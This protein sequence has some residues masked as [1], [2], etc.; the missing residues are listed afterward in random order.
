MLKLSPIIISVALLIGCFGEGRFPVV[1]NSTGEKFALYPNHSMVME[2]KVKM[3]VGVSREMIF[4]YIKNLH[5]FY[6]E[7]HRDHSKFDFI[8]GAPGELNAVIDCREN[9]DGMF[10]Q[11]RYKI[12]RII[13]NSY[14][15]LVSDPSVVKAGRHE[16]PCATI[17]E[18]II[19]EEQEKL[20]FTTKVTIAY[21]N[22]FTLRTAQNKKYR[23]R[24]IW[25]M[26][27][28]EETQNA[29]N[30]LM[31]SLFAKQYNDDL[32]Q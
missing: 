14:I 24:E 28:E 6:L 26:H 32:S 21:G 11:H 8:S 15:R 30:I 29:P 16:I 25:Q 5:N 31:S 17:A 27:I 7:T 4:Y 3:P 13:E 9:R 18:Y 1:Q 22:D 20:Y 19:S 2:H 23:T 10:L 12:T